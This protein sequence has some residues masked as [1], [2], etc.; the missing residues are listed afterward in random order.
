MTSVYSGAPDPLQPGW[1]ALRRGDAA[2][3]RNVFGRLV[4][5]RPTDANAWYGLAMA[6][7]GVG[8]IEGHLTALDRALALVPDH[9][10]ALLMK[11]DHYAAIGDDRAAQAFYGAAVS[12][13]PPLEQLPPDF[14]EAVR[15]A[16]R[17]NARYAGLFE[18]RLRASLAS[19]GYRPG[20]SSRRVDQALDLMLGK[21]EV[22]LQSPT[23]F[24]FPELPQRQ[25]FEREEFDW[26][27]AL[28]SRT[29]EIR[30]ELVEVLRDERGVEPYVR[31]DGSRPPRNLGE[32]ADN[33]SWSAFYLIK[34]GSVV[35]EHAARCPRTMAALDEV[36]LS[37]APGRTPSVLFS[38]LRPRS[39]IGAH[40]GQLNTRLICHLPL[41][42]PGNGAL[43]VGNET[44]SWV[45][46]E[47]LI[48]DDSIEH[49]AWNDSDKLRGILLFEV[50]RPE[51]TV[52]ER[53]L[54]AAML[55]S[56]GRLDEG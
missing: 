48:F 43:R 23:A 40:N 30:E 52:E 54:V 7:R 27:E 50:W 44:R 2:T 26:I 56:V 41:I 20:D 35:E 9:L 18:S 28:E 38:L 13:A 10:P 55:S 3:S 45:E 8:D 29:A 16:E 25:F 21:R 34:G 12:R 39:R 24:Y 53:R 19:E 46:G 47:V 17:E 33:P 32:L 37:R 22:F 49:E 15:R 11:A 36:P 6:A 31:S 42:V 4:A 51:L 5:V 1:D 14:R